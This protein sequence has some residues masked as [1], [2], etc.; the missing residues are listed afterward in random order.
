MDKTIEEMKDI[1]S[2]NAYKNPTWFWGQA[3][4]STCC[5]QTNDLISTLEALEECSKALHKSI[6]T[7]RPVEDLKARE[8][9]L[10]LSRSYLELD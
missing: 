4:F 5:L 2:K 8:R 10:E 9:F 3:Y 1:S 7:K 6:D